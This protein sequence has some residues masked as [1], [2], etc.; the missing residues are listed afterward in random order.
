M[1]KP[2]PQPP[3][4][5]WE[6]TISGYEIV[7]SLGRTAGSNLYRVR[8]VQDE[9]LAL[10]KRLDEKPDPARAERFRTEHELLA[11]LHVPG[12][13]RP[14]ALLSDG[15]EPA[16]LLE[17]V[18]GELLE[19][20]LAEPMPLARALRF[21]LQ[22]ACSL[23]GLHDKHTVHR[24]L[25]PVNLL[26][27]SANDRISIVDV[28]WAA[29]AGGCHAPTHDE[30][31]YISPEQTGR[32]DRPVDARSDLYSLGV[33]LYRMLS[34]RLP[35]AAADALEW[36]HCHLARPP[37]PIVELVPDLPEP[38]AAL[39][40]KLLAKNPGERYQS[41][42]GVAADL[43][44][45]LAE[46]EAGRHV[47]DFT[48]ASRD[49][50]DRIAIPDE[51]F[52]RE[53]QMAQLHAAWDRTLAGAAAEMVLVSGYSGIG[54]TSLVNELREHVGARGFFLTGKFDQ[55]KRDI[56]YASFRQA[57]QSL[58]QQLLGGSEA[59]LQQWRERLG[60]ALGPN[61]QL[62]TAI[63]PELEHIIG[64]QPA[65]PELAAFEARNRFHL[66]FQK[67]LGV[68]AAEAHPLVL[69]IDDLQWLDPASLTLLEYLETQPGTHYLLFIGAYREN[70]LTPGHPLY[71]TLEAIRKAGT[72]ISPLA[73]GP[74]SRADIG[75]LLSRALHVSAEAATPLADAVHEKT[76]GNP[77]FATQFLLSLHDEGAIRLDRASGE[78][79]WDIAEILAR[80]VTDNVVDLLLVKLRRL[81]ARTQVAIA[82]M[83]CLGNR[84]ETAI[85][86]AA[87]GGTEEEV[88]DALAEAAQAGLIFRSNRSY[89]FLHDRVQEAGYALLP[90]QE[91]AAT[92]L[93][94]A[95]RLSA[96]LTPEEIAERVFDLAGQWNRG[97]TQLDNPA[98][99]AQLIGLNAL[100]GARAKSSAA[101]ASA[102][103][104]YAN[105]AAL[106]PDDAWSARYDTTLDLYLALAE[107]ECLVGAYKQS[108][109][110]LEL[111]LA[112]ARTDV[113]AARAYILRIRLCQLAGNYREAVLAMLE[114]LRALG[115]TLPESDD[116]ITTAAHAEL[117]AV[118]SLLD[119]QRAPGFVAP[120]AAT[121][122]RTRATLDLLDEGDSA[123]FV[124]HPRL[125]PLVVIRSVTIRLQYGETVHSPAAYVSAGMAI[126]SVTGDMTR[127]LEVSEMAVGPDYLARRNPSADAGKLIAKHA[128]MVNIWCRHFA[129]SL[130]LLEKA[131][132]AC[133]EVGDFLF[134]GYMTFNVLWLEFESGMTL[135]AVAAAAQKWAA[136]AKET[137][138]EV[139]G[140]V[141]RGGQRFV[142]GLRGVYDIA[143]SS[144][145]F[146]EAI[147]KQTAARFNVGVNFLLAMRQMTAFFEGRYER[148]WQHTET[149]AKTVSA[150][151]LLAVEAV[152]HTFRGLTAAALYANA[153]VERRRELVEVVTDEVRRHEH[154]RQHGPE[155]FAARHALLSAELARM[156]GRLVAA[157][158]F[159]EDAIASA[160]EQKLLHYEAL[161]RELASRFY[162]GRGLLTIAD[163]YLREARD[164]YRIWGAGAKVKQIDRDYP[165]LEAASSAGAKGS[166]SVR[167]EA[168]DLLAVVKASQAI[169]QQLVLDDLITTL[170]RVVLE[171]AGAETG[172]LLLLRGGELNVA[173]LARVD[174]P[175]IV[176]RQPDDCATAAE[177]PLSVLNYVRRSKER[178]VLSDL[179]RANAFSAD[180]TLLRRNPKS[181]LCLPIVLQAEVVG[182]LYLENGALA[183][184]FPPNRVEM[185]ALLAGQAAIS[186]QHARLYADLQ[187]E[188]LERKRAED[189]LRSSQDLLHGIVDNSRT[190]IYVK[191]LE[192]R[193][194]LVN[195]HLA[196]VL[197]RDRESLLGK[198]DF[199]LF[200]HE[201][202]SAYRTVDLR[203]LTGGVPVEAEELG[204]SPDGVHTYLS[205]KSPLFDPNG[206]TYGLCG[207]STDITERKRTEEALRQKEAELRQAQKMEAI[208]NLAGGVAHDFNN[209]LTVILG[210]CELL[211]LQIGDSHA[212]DLHAIEEAGQRAAALTQQLLAFSRKQLLQPQVTDLNQVVSRIERML[213]RLIGEDIELIVKADAA[214][215]HVLVDPGQ[216]EQI[217][218]NLAVNAR[219]AMPTG[220]RL[221]IE[222]GNVVLD[223]S[224][225]SHQ[226]GVVP[227]PHVVLSVSDTGIG[228]DAPT[229]SRIFEPFFTTKGPG[230]GT[231]L[232]L[233]TVF[234]IVQQS[235]GAIQVSSELGRGTTFNVY[236]PHTY[237]SSRPPA[238]SPAPEDRDS[239][240]GSE[241][242]LLV[243]DDELV[244][245]LTR[246]L[247]VEAG[248]HVLEA[249]SAE[250]ALPLAE[251]HAGRI[252]LLVTDVVLPRVG[253]RQLADQLSAR[254][255]ETKVLFMSGYT[256]DSIIRHGV[257]DSAVELLQKPF[258]RVSL[259]R[260][261]RRMFDG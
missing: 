227:G 110:L 218:M 247:L 129:T 39:V 133:V 165:H 197:Q 134:I 124:A 51:L 22:L 10:L 7:K 148:A 130:P 153:G 18:P 187:R 117:R 191:D 145:D 70:E 180:E 8:G 123:T 96:S 58:V 1:T 236:F 71:L 32:T 185:L 239:L 136:I 19:S 90:L 37:L 170:M 184:A 59:E 29:P 64:R 162:R 156:E 52:G 245:G 120:G 93:G 43:A 194:L 95:R 56:P 142:A 243:E 60:D 186:L 72:K 116:E 229:Q 181:L 159:Y 244:R 100:A 223:E 121:D 152:H 14:L 111:I 257:V 240:K 200:P 9:G 228:M 48:L 109:E 3:E 103:A 139:M 169:S 6:P 214:L 143:S 25:R 213:R 193:F 144:F 57:F 98:E 34:G 27:S 208:G 250:A 73:V 249:E 30:L 154:W 202:A 207:I 65:A 99:I 87:H 224:Y 138:N 253:G 76:G 126:A 49:I 147:A 188:N 216:A 160:G 55:R 146:D 135:E 68:F 217:L 220:G 13:P 219:D 232:G 83:A 104:Y 259:L 80:S 31:A 91:R 172:A 84:V 199:D 206:K 210:S 38:I 4:S 85:L 132:A 261:V 221:T 150:V 166:S 74:L 211:S 11:S 69:F 171:S 28:S 5:R 94:I 61:G 46:W 251:Q 196:E 151:K 201:Q 252:H 89:R 127:A 122:P 204:T 248:Y 63:I 205:V 41:G 47:S 161:A 258:T 78:F 35:F 79:R 23:S 86:A 137:H 173:A 125:W 182:L 149:M 77:F 26:V 102:R 177:L 66:A 62:I 50:A 230:K 107:C 21:A 176:V 45:C 183:H 92:H 141:V 88:H 175:R 235:G 155:N 17:D 231:G 190:L 105:A 42:R 24:D 178:V 75:A 53:P 260:S 238:K 82:E 44:R 255:P 97:A 115:M 15:P 67:F 222:T 118:A 33:I 212:A 225:A 140:E 114:G 40:S 54:K 128:A 254:H 119:A 215:G 113:D 241:T 108:A 164:S 246:T 81:S 157:E 36:M 256:N 20:S 12:I 2:D 131:Y 234:G 189:A 158:H 167:I 112:R 195:R 101:Y 233:S 174:G 226:V 163:T 237:R 16:M 179:A 198:T 168:L 203:V 242:I 209:L 106:L 192:G